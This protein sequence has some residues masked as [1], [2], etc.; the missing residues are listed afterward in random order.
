MQRYKAVIFDLDG[1]LL[2]TLDDITAGVNYAMSEL[3]CP[4]RSREEVCS[5]IGNGARMLIAR[6]LP[7]GDERVDEALAIFRS[8]YG[9]HC[10]VHTRPFPGMTEL[11]EQLRDAGCRL[12]I[13]SNK[14]HAQ[15]A[16]LAE[17]FFP[18]VPA[19]GERENTPRKPDPTGLLCMIASLGC[20]PDEVLYVGD[21]PVDREVAGNAGTHC[22]LVT[23]GFRSASVLEP[24]GA[25]ALVENSAQLSHFIF[26]GMVT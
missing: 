1:T 20:T 9:G 25:N 4:S 3:G 7:K 10:A 19:V 16:E 23:W 24:L 14:P 8:Y 15:T 5:F 26:S 22:A 11:V 6:S 2:D 17:K 12:G 21:S 13:V 18:G